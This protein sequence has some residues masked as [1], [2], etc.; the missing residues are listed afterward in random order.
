MAP[1]A[2]IALGAVACFAGLQFLSP[3]AGGGSVSAAVAAVLAT[4]PAAGPPLGAHAGGCPPPRTP[5]A[6]TRNV[7]FAAVGDDWQPSK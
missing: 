6:K 5:G 1:I 4:A 3:G 7:V 2:W